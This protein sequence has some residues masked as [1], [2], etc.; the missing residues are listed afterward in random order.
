MDKDER[1]AKIVEVVD[2]QTVETPCRI[3]SFVFGEMRTGAIVALGG[4]E[5]IHVP[6]EKLRHNFRHIAHWGDSP[7]FIKSDMV[8]GY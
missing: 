2:G 7:A 8:W 4:G 5:I 3:M 6:I 1:M